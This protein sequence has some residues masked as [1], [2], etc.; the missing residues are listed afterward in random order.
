VNVFR[1][2]FKDKKMALRSLVKRF[3]LVLLCVIE[4]KLVVVNEKL[5]N[6]IW[7][8]N[9][10]YWVVALFIGILRGIIYVW[11]LPIFMS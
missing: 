7:D 6:S 2:G 8:R 1:V 3:N 4:M 10:R 5:I 11:I 9:T